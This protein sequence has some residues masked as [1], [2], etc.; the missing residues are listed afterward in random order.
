MRRFF[1]A[2]SNTG[3]FAASKTTL[4]HPTLPPSFAAPTANLHYAASLTAAV[5][6]LR[7]DGSR[8]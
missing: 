7:R 2:S 8:R 6:L 1:F 4:L 5:T 3:D